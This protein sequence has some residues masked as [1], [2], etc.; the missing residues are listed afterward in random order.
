MQ[1]GRGFALHLLAM[2]YATDLAEKK[3]NHKLVSVLPPNTDVFLWDAPAEP[4]GLVVA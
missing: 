4:T 2:R 3:A 1:V